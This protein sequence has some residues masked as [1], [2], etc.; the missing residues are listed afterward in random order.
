VRRALAIVALIVRASQAGAQTSDG[1]PTNSQYIR[2]RWSAAQGFPGSAVSA[3]AQTPDGYLWIGTEQGL[4]RFDGLEFRPEPGTPGTSLPITRVLGLATDADGTLWIRLQGARLARYRHGRF[5][6]VLAPVVQNEAGFTAMSR[7]QM[8]RAILTGLRGGLVRADSKGIATILPPAKLPNSLAIALAESSDGTIWIGTRDIGAFQV[9]AGGFEPGPTDL[10]DR[11]VNCLLPVA[12]GIL[13]IGTDAGIARWD[14]RAL[15]R[16]AARASPGA[17]QALVMIEDRAGGA[18]VGTSRGVVRLRVDGSVSFDGRDAAASPVT[19][20]FEDREGSLWMGTPRGIERWRARTFLTYADGPIGDSNGPV[21]VDARSRVWFAPGTGGLAWF[22]GAATGRVAA[23]DGDV[24]YSIAGNASGLWVGRQQGGLTHLA[25]V[26]GRFVART[27]RVADGLAQNSV[28]A[29]MTARDG[30]IWA[31]TL[32]G[33]VS[34]LANGRFTTYTTAEGL[35]SNSVSA[36]AEDA[37][38]VVWLGT[39]AGLSRFSSGRWTTFGEREGLPSLEVNAL[40]A[41]SNVMWVGTSAG[42]ASIVANTVRVPRTTPAVLKQPVHGMATIGIGWLWV[43]TASQVLRVSRAALLGGE[44]GAADVREY[45]LADGLRSVETM[46]RQPSVVAGGD[47]RIWFSLS[48]SLSV[49]DPRQVIDA[50][51]PAIVHMLGVSADGTA[52]TMNASAPL[53]LPSPR[54]R[55]TF[56]F[57]GLSLAVPERIRYR[58]R[59]DGF[60]SDWSEPT[61]AKEVAYTNLASG[62]YTFRVMASNSDGIWNGAEAAVALDIGR[63]FWQTS[64][65]RGAVTAS[66][67]LMAI[68]AYRF[69]VHQMTKQLNV[70][71]EE[72]LAERT[73]IAQE[74]HDTLLQGF[75]SAS[76]QLHVAAETLPEDSPA[77]PGL[78]RVGALMRQVIDEGRNAVRGL[79]STS[80]GPYDL[81]Q[82][83]SNVQQELGLGA[84]TGFRVIVEGQPRPLNPLVRD[85]IY[86]IGRE[87]LVNAFRHAR[88]STVEVELEYGPKH[89]RMLVRDDGVGIEPEVLKSG[90]DGHWGLSG[91]RERAERIGARFKVFSRAAAGTEVELWIPSHIAWEPAKGRR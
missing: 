78:T 35:P 82:A 46:K 22:D 50:S 89:M 10:P 55:I 87:A 64:W 48:R 85:E 58:Y 38:G 7:D 74:L 88:A 86:R 27:Y 6:D 61:A 59:L 84:S 69:R 62:P 17:N 90:T 91:M 80:P 79:R 44:V 67:L 29:V 63:V 57:G 31:G 18:W 3:I 15:T 13:W 11:K 20:L 23:L 30:S 34:H 54:Q 65:F 4:V 68:G 73:R 32:S 8:G 28:F 40:Y 37:E 41:E 83:L 26:G 45:G 36:I 14:G 16:V 75:L 52:M 51:P 47:R 72:R 70:R 2:D 25:D 9:R 66:L 42:L 19:A 43:A 71:F 76:M 49:V 60:D 21:F 53:W 5:E 56:S 33:G 24:V 1:S 81:G 39:P 77:R 12:N